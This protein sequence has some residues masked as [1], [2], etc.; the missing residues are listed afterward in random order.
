MSKMRNT[1]DTAKLTPLRNTPA[2]KSAD[3]KTVEQMAHSKTETPA[4][5]K[6]E[7]KA[8]HEKDRQQHDLPENIEENQVSGTDG[9]DHC[10]LGNKQITVE[11]LG[12]CR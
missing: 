9:A 4:K 2:H 6:A 1:L 12:L 11:S 10:P 5:A 8:D 7:Q 3:Q